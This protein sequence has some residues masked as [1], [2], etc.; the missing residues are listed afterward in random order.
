MKPVAGAKLIGVL[1]AL[2]FFSVDGLACAAQK[3]KAGSP[4]THMSAKTQ[5]NTNTQWFADPE[6]GWV[7]YGER[8]DADA[9]QKNTA[10]DN[11][12]HN[13]KTDERRLTNY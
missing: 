11:K 13:K 1:S 4:E 3:G 9:G 2:I 12:K 10:R 5:E 6:R 8:R 7:R